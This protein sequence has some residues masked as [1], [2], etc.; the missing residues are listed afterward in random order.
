MKIGILTMHRVIHFGSVLQAFAL[1]QT[2]LKMG[3]KNEIIDYVYPNEWHVPTQKQNIKEKIYSYFKKI[4]PQKQSKIEEFISKELIKTSKTYKTPQELALKCPYFD[5]YITGSDQVWNTDY[6]KGDK[7][8]FFNFLPDGTKKISYASS[9]GRFTFDGEAAKE[10]LNNLSTYEALS[11]REEKAQ[12]IIKKYTGLDS[13]LV[14]DPTL[15]ISKEEWE[16]F[17]S[18]ERYVDDDYILVYMLTYAWQPFPYALQLIQ[19]FE[20]MLGWKVVVIE[21]LNLR[22]KNP[23]WQYVEN[24][25]PHEFINL[26]KNA[27][28][29]LT[30]SFHG[31]AFSINL[32]RPFYSLVSENKVNDDRISS[33]CRNLN[34]NDNLL[35]VNSKMPLFPEMDFCHTRRLLNLY[36]NQSLSFLKCNLRQKNR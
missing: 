21:P 8:F 19:H 1:Q 31:T 3:L 30:S 14:L 6:L 27:G 10:W 33:L 17:A 25:S 4:V 9:F 18:K 7:S 24:I 12:K 22:E 16:S 35:F 11:V 26:F 29:I 20:K 5:I 2:L 23:Q 15:L 13:E 32:E 36:R 34:L 28:L